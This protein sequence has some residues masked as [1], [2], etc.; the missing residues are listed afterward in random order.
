[1][2]TWDTQE[3]EGKSQGF[4]TRETP[5]TPSGVQYLELFTLLSQRKAP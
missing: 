1:M 2:Q 4:S 5:Q 3:G